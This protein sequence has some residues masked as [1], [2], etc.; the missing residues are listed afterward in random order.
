[1]VFR[2]E[3]SNTEI[4]NSYGLRPQWRCV[5]IS[6]IACSGIG[7][8]RR[9]MLLPGEIFAMPRCFRFR[10]KGGEDTASSQ[11]ARI[12]AGERKKRG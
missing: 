9:A 8:E 12:T 11:T 3:I 7:M 2:R 6:V 10:L 4:A 1:V 5:G